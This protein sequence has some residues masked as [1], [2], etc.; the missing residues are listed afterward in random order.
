MFDPM[1]EV[2]EKRIAKKISQ[3]NQRDKIEDNFHCAINNIL[4][5]NGHIFESDLENNETTGESV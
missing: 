3:T 5:E 2:Y 4:T 1:R